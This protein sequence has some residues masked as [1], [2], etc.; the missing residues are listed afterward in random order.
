VQAPEA[1]PQHS[2]KRPP[3]DSLKLLAAAFAVIAVLYVTAPFS[4]TIFRYLDRVLRLTPPAS[5]WMHRVHLSVVFGL[6]YLAFV[7]WTKLFTRKPR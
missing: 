7:G 3:F 1:N 6:G 4:D 5:L 2:K